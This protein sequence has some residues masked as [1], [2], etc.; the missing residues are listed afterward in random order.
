MY[1]V[2]FHIYCAERSCRAQILAGA[3]TDAFFFIHY[4]NPMSATA[5]D[6]RFKHLYGSGRTFVCTMS[7]SDSVRQYETILCYPYGMTYLD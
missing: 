4:W 3:A 5:F 2:T 1:F 7:A 6:F